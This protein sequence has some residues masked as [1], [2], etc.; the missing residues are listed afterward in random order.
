MPQVNWPLTQKD[1]A[2]QYSPKDIGAGAHQ[3]TGAKQIAKE[4]VHHNG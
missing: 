2:R 1:G 4:G 3:E